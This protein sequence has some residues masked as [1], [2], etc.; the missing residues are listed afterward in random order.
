MG[1]SRCNFV[2]GARKANIPTIFSVPKNNY[3][4]AEFKK[5]E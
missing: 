3:L 1:R 2:S 5:S 4:A